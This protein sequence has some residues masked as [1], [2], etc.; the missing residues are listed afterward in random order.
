MPIGINWMY[1]FQKNVNWLVFLQQ[2]ENKNLHSKEF[3]ATRNLISK[4]HKSTNTCDWQKHYTF[5]RDHSPTS[6]QEILNSFDN[7]KIIVFGLR[8]YLTTWN[9]NKKNKIVNV[10]FVGDDLG[11]KNYEGTPPQN[12]MLNLIM[13][14][15][16]LSI[17]EK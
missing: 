8:P 11:P 14:A 7:Q 13:L 17:A 2:V 1:T 3:P 16:K 12:L 5:I 6:N 15:E 9:S 10:F 4:F